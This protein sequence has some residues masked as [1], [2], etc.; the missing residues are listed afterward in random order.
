MMT[1]DLDELSISLILPEKVKSGALVPGSLV[2]TNQGQTTV[3]AVDPGYHGALNLV[4]FSP[5]WDQVFPSYM[6][7]IHIARSEVEIAAGE[8]KS[9]AFN[10]LVFTT[11]T[12]AV[13]FR[14]PPGVY[15]VAAFYHPGFTAVV[16]AVKTLVVE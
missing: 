2:V 4:V 14:L 15:Y 6:G 10:D 16:S 3:K 9:F 7:K 5:T 8:S 11:G 13:G 12:A 1:G